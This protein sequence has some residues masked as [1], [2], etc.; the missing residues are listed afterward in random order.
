MAIDVDTKDCTAVSDADL[1]HMADICVDGPNPY[2]VGFLSKQTE[3]W[4]LLTTAHDGSRLKAF[5]F[6]TLER[7]GGTPSVILGAASVARTSKRDTALRGM[8]T[9]QMRRAL[10]AFPDEDVLVGTRVQSPAGF[11]VF[12]SLGELIPRPEHRANGEERAWGKRLA[13]RFEIPAGAYDDRTFLAV[14]D[15]SQQA[16]FDHDS[17]KPTN[18]PPDLDALFSAIDLGRGD[19]LVTHGW[20][21]AEELVKLA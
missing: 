9:D 17:L 8:V 11:E 18:A 2:S 21:L 13:K 16:V 4:V 14:G 3:A 15:G 6:C 1:E 5:S 7:I 19:S 20:A 10:L 12:R